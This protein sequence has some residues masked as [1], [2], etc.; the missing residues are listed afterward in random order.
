MNNENVSELFMCIRFS[1][2]KHRYSNLY[3]VIRNNLGKTENYKSV[4]SSQETPKRLANKV[5]V[6]RR[7]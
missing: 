2:K 7:T 1:H 5:K 3:R 4:F 6:E